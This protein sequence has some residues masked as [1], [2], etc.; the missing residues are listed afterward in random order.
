LLDEALSAFSRS[1]ETLMGSIAKKQQVILAEKSL[2]ALGLG[3]GPASFNTERAIIHFNL[4]ADTLAGLE[5]RR[6]NAA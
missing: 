6:V 4:G 2:L 5:R 1:F 3:N